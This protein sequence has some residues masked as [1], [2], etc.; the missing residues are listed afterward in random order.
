MVSLNEVPAVW[1]EGVGTV[2]E[3]S[4]LGLTRKAPEAPEVAP[5]DATVSVVFWASKRA[6]LAVPTPLVK[7]IEAG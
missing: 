3:P 5:A 2:K 1:V 4:V 6:M 7:V